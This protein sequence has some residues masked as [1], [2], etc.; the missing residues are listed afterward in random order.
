[1]QVAVRKTIFNLI[2]GLKL[3]CLFQ[4]P[5]LQQL[6]HNNG[7]PCGCT[8]KIAFQYFISCNQ[9]Q[10]QQEYITISVAC[11]AHAQFCTIVFGDQ[12]YHYYC[13]SHNFHHQNQFELDSVMCKK[14]H[15]YL[16]SLLCW[17]RLG[18]VIM[19]V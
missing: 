6:N 16:P 9:L 18:S 1:M 11:T 13:H 10:S 7:M 5:K 2:Y 17:G 8:S 3:F 15:R 4:K 12:N 14:L 19:I